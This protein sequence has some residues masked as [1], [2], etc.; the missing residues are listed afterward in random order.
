MHE[1]LLPRKDAESNLSE[2][3]RQP[4]MD[5][6]LRAQPRAYAGLVRRLHTAGMVTF[7]AAPREKCGLFFVRKKSGKQRMVIDCRRANCWF[8]RPSTVA[9]ATGSA[10]GELAVPEGEQLY[11]GHVDICDAFYHFG[12]PEAF[13]EYFALPAVKAGDVGLTVLGG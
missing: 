5:A 4:Y 6:I 11:V 8:R 3:P 1:Q 9:L 13:R 2:A 7:S 12:L 10:L